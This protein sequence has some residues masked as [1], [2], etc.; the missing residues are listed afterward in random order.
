M[1]LGEINQFCR[2]IKTHQKNPADVK[3][4]ERWIKEFKD[5]VRKTLLEVIKNNPVSAQALS[6]LHDEIQRIKPIVASK[7]SYKDLSTREKGL[8]KSICRAFSNLFK[9]RTS[10]KELMNAIQTHVIDLNDAEHLLSSAQKDGLSKNVFPLIANLPCREIDAYA[11]RDQIPALV[12][13]D[14]ITVLS[15]KNE[16]EVYLG[17]KLKATHIPLPTDSQKDPLAVDLLISL[18]HLMVLAT[19]AADDNHL[20]SGFQ[21]AFMNLRNVELT[22]RR[23]KIFWKN[24]HH[25]S[26]EMIKKNCHY[27]PRWLIA[28]LANDDNVSIRQVPNV[29]YYDVSDPACENCGY[30]ELSLN[31]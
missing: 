3:K 8:W 1:A 15:V 5:P 29:D 20:L 12:G 14:P 22:D 28:R 21:S 11:G 6:T 4:Y 9:N 18:K 31:K 2:D 26:S 19:D 10:S 16:G 25:D 24:D 13:N 27:D 30:W 17:L 7:Q 23:L